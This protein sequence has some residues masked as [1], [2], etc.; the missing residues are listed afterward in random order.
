MSEDDAEAVVH[1][2]VA[3][4]A[5]PPP[6]LLAFRH[7]LTSLH[8]R[9]QFLRGCG[10]WLACA[11]RLPHLHRLS[12]VAARGSDRVAPAQAAALTSLA[13][14]LRSLT[15]VNC[16]LP[17]TFSEAL[18]ALT[19]LTALHVASPEAP[20][21]LRLP[22]TTLAP[23]TRLETLDFDCVDLGIPT[24]DAWSSLASLSSLKSFHLHDPRLAAD[25]A[26]GI[27][28]LGF[29]PNLHD[30]KM[31]GVCS[32]PPVASALT[33]LHW[34]PVLLESR[35]PEAEMAWLEV[36]PELPALRN[37]TF[38]AAFFQAD[39]VTP[40]LGAVVAGAAAALTSLDLRGGEAAF[41]D[42]SFVAAATRLESL[43]VTVDCTLE[44]VGAMVAPFLP[45]LSALTALTSLTLDNGPREWNVEAGAAYIRDLPNL[46]RLDLRP[47]PVWTLRLLAAGSG[48][49]RLSEAS[50]V[51]SPWRLPGG[52]E[53]N[54]P[55]TGSGFV[56]AALATGADPAVLPSLHRLSL[57]NVACT[58]EGW[59][60]AARC[61]PNVQEMEIDGPFIVSATQ[62][63]DTEWAEEVEIRQ[64]VVPIA[65]FFTHLQRLRANEYVM[66]A[67]DVAQAR[68]PE[69]YHALAARRRQAE[70]PAKLSPRPVDPVDVEW[71]G[72][73]PADVMA[74]DERYRYSMEELEE[75]RGWQKTDNAAALSRLRLP[76]EL[77]R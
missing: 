52:K 26:P 66:D 12:L 42:A 6:D 49:R 67:G 73:V 46:R 25:Y 64:Q 29:L 22:P 45:H 48:L 63:G 1:A 34:E 13:P 56:A 40:V 61:C 39:L 35:S 3:A 70:R 77:Q 11:S 71:L 31:V 69:P 43:K 17:P 65:H 41:T 23:L 7:S 62:I 24:S 75:L 19:G 16:S 2:L 74:C 38:S 57:C 10:R 27:L 55:E 51:S 59:E 37:V 36:R 20:D 4:G 30:F 9:R 47:A 76:P 53:V 50:L 8:I 60:S 5:L 14:T 33:S 54:T 72:P 68:L 44:P 28:Y 18:S 58:P 15:L 32:C 21:A